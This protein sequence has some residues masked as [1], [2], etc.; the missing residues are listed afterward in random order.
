[1]VLATRTVRSAATG[2]DDLD[3]RPLDAAADRSLEL[4]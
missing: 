3:T 1:V 2:P 4:G